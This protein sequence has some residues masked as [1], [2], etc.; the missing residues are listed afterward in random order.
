MPNLHHVDYN[1]KY[2]ATETI[3]VSECPRR[4]IFLSTF[5][6]SL[7]LSFCL[8]LSRTL[9][10]AN[11][12]LK[13]DLSAVIKNKTFIYELP[14]LR[15][16]TRSVGAGVGVSCLFPLSFALRFSSCLPSLSAFLISSIFHTRKRVVCPPILI[17]VLRVFLSEQLNKLIEEFLSLCLRFFLFVLVEFR[18]G[19]GG[20]C[21]TTTRPLAY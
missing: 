3:Q 1:R 7:S 20:G 4:Q 2:S 9:L 12:H 8:S 19:G 11:W 10:L 13:L 15:H 18:M 16:A 14:F 17:D 5:S 21:C 6:S